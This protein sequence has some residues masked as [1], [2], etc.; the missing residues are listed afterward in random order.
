MHSQWRDCQAWSNF[1]LPLSTTSNEA[2]KMYDAVVAQYVGVYS[3]KSVGGIRKALGTMTDADPNFV[4]GSALANILSVCGTS[5]NANTNDDIRKSID[6]MMMMMNNNNITARERLHVEAVKCFAE[7]DMETACSKWETILVDHPTDIVAIKLAHDGYFFTGR[8]EQMRDSTARVLPHWNKHMPFYGNLLGNHAFGLVETNLFKEAEDTA[9]EGLDVN[10]Y[11]AWSTHS[12]NHVMEYTGRHKEGI[13]FLNSTLGTWDKCDI[14]ASHNY[15]H[16]AVFHIDRGEYE[17]ALGIYDQDI[18]PRA[19][20]IKGM[21][22]ILDAT[23]FLYRLELEGQNVGDRW[24]DI[25]DLCRP[26]VEDHVIMLNDIHVLM[27]CLGARHTDLTKKLMDTLREYVSQ[28]SKQ[29]KS[30]VFQDVGLPL[31]EAFVA[32]D[33]GDYAK[34]VDLLHPVRYK[35][36]NIGGS[37]AQRD[38]FNLFLIDAALKSPENRHRKLARCLLTERKAMRKNSPLTD[39]LI[40]RSLALHVD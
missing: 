24:Q 33:D 18:A 5:Q 6:K 34:A 3:D 38:V 39:R 14:F 19:L 10:P 21:L 30:G 7:G 37:H 31:C 32:A 26:H 13:Q 4:L 35:V 1:G 23:S 15:W 36:V 8:S 17:E 16:W 29:H 2:A 27:G 28:H 40:A 11:D 22:E 25:I 20:K 9:R 12:L